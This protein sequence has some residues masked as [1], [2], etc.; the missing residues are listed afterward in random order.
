MMNMPHLLTK[1]T[2]LMID[3]VDLFVAN[4]SDNMIDFKT[5]TH[6][7]V[8]WLAVCWLLVMGQ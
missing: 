6:D 5:F 7:V 1:L 4:C 8:I 2:A 3:E